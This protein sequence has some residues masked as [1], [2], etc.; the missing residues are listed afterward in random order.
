MDMLCYINHKF[1]NKRLKY[2]SVFADLRPSRLLP[3]R[4]AE[5][6]AEPETG[7]TRSVR[8]P[9]AGPASYSATC[10]KQ[11]LSLPGKTGLV[12]W[13]SHLPEA[14]AAGEEFRRRKCPRV[15]ENRN[16]MHDSF[17]AAS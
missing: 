8:F 3:L 6:T 1:T 9:T 2:V 14:S 15:K 4:S 7:L 12:K 17:I 10:K 11:Y 13:Y 5:W 16:F